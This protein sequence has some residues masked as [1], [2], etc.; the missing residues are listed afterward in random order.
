MRPTERLDIAVVTMFAAFLVL[1]AGC[2]E[3]AD[4]KVTNLVPDSLL[5]S[6]TLDVAQA[7][8]Y[9]KGRAASGMWQSERMVT[10]NWHGYQSRSFLSLS[11]PDTAFELQSAEL[12]L[13]ATRIE[14]DMASSTFEL[15]TLADSILA[16]DIYWS[17]MPQPDELL[18][19]FA[20]PDPGPGAIVEDS[21]F[22]D[23]TT[24]VAEW[25]SGESDNYGLVMKLDSEGTAAEAIA[26]FGTSQS[27]NRPVEDDE[28]DT[29]LVDVR[30]SM[31]VAYRDTANDADT[32]LW[33]LPANDTFSDT[34]VTPLGGSL[35]TVGNGFPS[36]AFIEFDL[37]A[38]PEGSRLSRAVLELTVSADSSSFDEISVICHAALE[39]WNGF[40]T[41]IGGQG[42]GT[43]TLSREDF[44]TDGVIRMEIS[45]LVIPQVGGVVANHG[46]VIKS[47]KEAFDLDYVRFHATPR[48]MVY[49][50]LPPEPWYRRD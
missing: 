38:I 7:G 40:D 19:T 29:T 47:T 12:Y 22:V 36:R 8:W 15:Y 11:R 4:F 3:R 42:V 6:D 37:G 14:G 34:L 27:R 35:L 24:V 25:I 2:S 28:G 9:N 30:P 18:A 44:E 26:E 43:T 23:I 13:Y 20:L 17:E 16:G 50:A 41:D 5:V 10:A 49:Y 32:T 21:V 33:Y 48:L 1:L 31:R 46:Y 39:A 45:E